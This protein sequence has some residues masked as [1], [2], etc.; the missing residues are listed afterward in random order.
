M[1]P[2]T[3]KGELGPLAIRAFEEWKVFEDEVGIQIMGPLVGGA[4]V[5]L[6]HLCRGNREPAVFCDATFLAS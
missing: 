2:D 6:K 3:L 4:M 5:A 1:L